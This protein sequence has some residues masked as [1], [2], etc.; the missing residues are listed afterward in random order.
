MPARIAFTID[1][2]GNSRTILDRVGAEKLLGRG[3]YVLM[4]TAAL[5]KPKR[6]Q[7]AWVTDEGLMKNF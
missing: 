3:E 5:P 1:L 7:G 4:S 2:T 6:I